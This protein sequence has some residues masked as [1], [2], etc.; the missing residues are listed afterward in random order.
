MVTK[1]VIGEKIMS[2]GTLTAVEVFDGYSHTFVSEKGENFGAKSSAIVLQQ[3][4]GSVQIK[5]EIVDLQDGLPIVRSQGMGIDLSISKG[6]GVKQQGDAILLYD[7]EKNNETILSITPFVCTAQDPIKDC[8][9]LK[10]NFVEYENDSFVA[11]QGNTFY[12]LGETNTWM[13]FA[14]EN[15]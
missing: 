4:S 5:G 7:K 1:H 8:A 13:T 3:F 11:S 15:R 10:R 9:T 12:N 14:H 6:Y 2:A